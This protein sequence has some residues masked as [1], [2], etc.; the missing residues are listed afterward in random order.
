MQNVAKPTTLRDMTEA[1]REAR[2]QVRSYFVIVEE[3]QGYKDMTL[4]ASLTSVLFSVDLQV[5]VLEETVV[6]V[7]AHRKKA[8]AAPNKGAD[9]QVRKY[10][11]MWEGTSRVTVNK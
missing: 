5:T 4:T 9:V 7:V 1:A 8:K 3:R 2:G 10:F 11:V 6:N